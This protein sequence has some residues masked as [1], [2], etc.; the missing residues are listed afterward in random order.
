MYL[1]VL[2]HQPEAQVGPHP[3]PLSKVERGGVY[4]ETFF[5]EWGRVLLQARLSGG[6]RGV[7][8]GNDLLQNILLAV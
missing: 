4:F 1:Q 5:Q 6:R 3:R 2:I 8:E 7:G